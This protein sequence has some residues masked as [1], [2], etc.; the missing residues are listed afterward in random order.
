MTGS[1]GLIVANGVDAVTGDYLLAPQ[2]VLYGMFMHQGELTV[3]D[4]QDILTP[5]VERMKEH[6]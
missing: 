4:E 3:Q 5:A 1:D 6:T 2:N